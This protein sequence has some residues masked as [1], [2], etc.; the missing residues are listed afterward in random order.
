[1]DILPELCLTGFHLSLLQTNLPQIRHTK[2]LGQD[3]GVQFFLQVLYVLL[4]VSSSTDM[5]SEQGSSYAAQHQE[6]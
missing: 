2:R 6:G 4:R 1:M 3:F 5:A